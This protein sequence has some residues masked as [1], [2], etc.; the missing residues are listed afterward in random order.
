MKKRLEAE[1]I[2]IAHRILKLKNKSELSQLYF[3]TQKLYETLSVLKFVEE[4]IGVVQSKMD[5]A[6]IE[7]KL[8]LALDKKELPIESELPLVTSEVFQEVNEAT[9]PELKEGFDDVIAAVSE[10]EISIEK[11][12]INEENDNVI[13]IVSEQ[14]SVEVPDAIK[15]PDPEFKPAFELSFEEKS[16]EKSK[17]Q[18][19]SFEDLLGADY[20]DPVFDK[21]EA[22][23]NPIAVLPVF[24]AETSV[25]TPKNELFEEKSIPKPDVANDIPNR[26]ITFGLNDR[27]GFEKQLFAG[28]SEDMNRVVSQ[29]STFGTFLEVQEFIED[30]VKPDYNNWEGKDDYALR[31]ME[32]VEKKFG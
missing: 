15:I 28:S 21:L 1:L 18:Q 32:I 26:N 5:V 4:N 13:P 24:E 23:K 27:I 3:E 19:I 31:F 7:E 12:E 17:T 20:N 22:D 25:E 30:M 8:H 16:E 2:S 11:E 10:S 14:E 29:L 9:E 6:D